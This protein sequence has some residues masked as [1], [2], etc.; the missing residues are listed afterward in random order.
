MFQKN[1]VTMREDKS[2]KDAVRL[3]FNLG[4]SAVIVTKDGKKLSGIVTEEDILLR[5]FPSIKD[6]IEDLVG[7]RDFASME[8]NLR[9]L[10][11]KPVKT[12]MTSKVKCVNPHTPL[13]NTLSMM[14]VNKF[15]HLPV[16]DSRDNLVGVISQ[17]DIFKTLSGKAVPYDMDPDYYNWMAY[18]H[19]FISHSQ[20]RYE[21]ETEEIGRIFRNSQISKII[22]IGCGVGGHSINLVKKGFACLG[23]ERSKKLF[24]DAQRARGEMSEENRT[25]LA[26]VLGQYRDYLD[27]V[28]GRFEGAILM[29]NV[30]SHIYDDYQGI[31]RRAYHV[32]GG[33][34]PTIVIQLANFEKILKVNHGFQDFN[35][36]LL[37]DERH[38]RY[39]FL[40]FYEKDAQKKDMTVLT[41]AVLLFNGRRWTMAGVNSTPVAYI[42]KEKIEA[43]LKKIGFKNLKFYG[44]RF[45][46]PILQR[47]PDMEKDDWITVVAQ[48]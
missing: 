41:M 16:V 5:L 26:F 48:K 25:K 15:S 4:I 45:G 46:E 47:K 36:S 8:E 17:G 40:E 21:T 24:A 34:N 11:E 29:G 20:K 19:N 32:L 38:K 23:L 6:Y 22:D 1:P 7:S 31:L 37:K 39:A 43:L 27:T 18:Y 9:E 2:V 14:L 30:L 28:K 33:K 42:T 35:I 44:S 10:L 12:I 3:I 13:M